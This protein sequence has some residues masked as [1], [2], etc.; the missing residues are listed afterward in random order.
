MRR[1]AVRRSV[2]AMR[3][4]RRAGP[5]LIVL[6]LATP[7]AAQDTPPAPCRDGGR[8]DEFDFWVGE[9]DVFGPN[10]TQAGTNVIEK[11]ERGCLIVE[12]WTGA[13]GGTGTSVNFYDP[14]SEVWRQLWVSSN[15]VVIEIEGGLRNGSMV[16]EGTLTN[17]AGR[18][19]PFRGTWTPNRDGSVRQ[20]FEISQDDGE[21]WSTWFDGRYVPRD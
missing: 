3:L 14:G 12:H 1:S 5:T 11:V 10:D 17:P 21:T 18:S 4:A 16:L 6:L 9:W 15:D 7:L 8:F 2:E 19:Q 13:G 20:H